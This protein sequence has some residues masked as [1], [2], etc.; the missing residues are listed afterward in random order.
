M[1]IDHRSSLITVITSV[2][3]TSQLRNGFQSGIRRQ[4]ELILVL[5]GLWHEPPSQVV[6]FTLKELRAHLGRR[7]RDEE[8][9][10]EAHS[11]HVALLHVP[12]GGDVDARHRSRGPTQCTQKL[13]EG[14]PHRRPEAE[15][16]ERVHHQAEIPVHGVQTGRR[17][18]KLNGH[19]LAL[20]DQVGV[21]L[22]ADSDSKITV[23]RVYTAQGVLK[24]CL[25]SY[26]L[27]SLKYPSLDGY[28]I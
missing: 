4:I 17:V 3:I 23:T 8:R 24:T 10:H 5:H 2:I 28:W 21:E 6:E 9:G 27:T 7:E 13:L 11:V 15:P 1:I 18:G 25:V 22:S 14:G 12:A 16:E 20:S 19:L 26:E